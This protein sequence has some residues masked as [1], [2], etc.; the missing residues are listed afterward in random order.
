MVSGIE[1]TQMESA[2]VLIEP[3]D[4]LVKPDILSADRGHS[5]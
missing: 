5:L 1:L 4:I 2:A 3:L